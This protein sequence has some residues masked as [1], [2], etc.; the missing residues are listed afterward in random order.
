MAEKD[1]YGIGVDEPLSGASY[2]WATPRALGALRREELSRW[3]DAGVAKKASH[4][5]VLDAQGTSEP[6]YVYPAEDPSMVKGVDLPAFG[7]PDHSLYSR[8]RARLVLEVYHLGMDKHVQ[9]ATHS[10][11]KPFL[12]YIPEGMVRPLSPEELKVEEPAPS[13][14]P[15]IEQL[16]RLCKLFN[17]ELVVDPQ[18]HE[19]TDALGATALPGSGEAQLCKNR[20]IAIAPDGQNLSYLVSHELAHGII[21]FCDEKDVLFEQT[22]ILARWVTELLKDIVGNGKQTPSR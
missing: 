18:P 13:E 9:L 7:D 20:V 4:L 19:R 5:L 2:S 8:W 17:Y 10:K 21:G 15:Q 6:L 1:E 16:Q 12:L 22:S 11:Q 14:N 3:F